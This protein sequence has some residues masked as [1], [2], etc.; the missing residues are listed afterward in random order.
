M[1]IRWPF[2]GGGEGNKVRKT[3]IKTNTKTKTNTGWPFKIEDLV[4]R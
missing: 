2:Q 4:I 3:N 1:S